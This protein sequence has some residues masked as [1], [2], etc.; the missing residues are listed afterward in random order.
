MT[1]NQQLIRNEAKDYIFSTLGLM[2]YAAAFTIFLLPYEIVTGGVIGMSSII[3][4]ATGFRIENTY[5]IIN[6]CLLIVGLKILGFKFLMKTIY[7][8]VALYFLIKFAQDLM[9]VDSEGH[10]V[11]ILGEGQEFMSLIVGCCLT[12][13]A[14]AIVFLNNSSTGGTD[15]IAWCVNKYRDISLGQVLMM[16]DVMIISS[17]LLFPQFGDFLQRVHKV[18]FGLSTMIVECFMIDHVMNLRRQSVQFLIFSNKYA[19]IAEAITKET[20]HSVTLLDGEGWYTG[21]EMKVVCL[22]AKKAES[23]SIFR[24]I[25]LIDPNAF[26]SQ[27]AVIGVFGEGFDK[28]KVSVSKKKRME[29]LQHSNH[30]SREDRIRRKAENIEGNDSNNQEQ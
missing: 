3:F 4:Y 22:L 1:I 24:L 6:I 23:A 7:A 29:M 10:F 17:S 9:P 15:I 16:V 8:I 13:S 21:K 25:K 28:I 14:L 18:V 2:L 11:K 19:Q 12:G 20:D 26:V 27:S 30:L 5:I